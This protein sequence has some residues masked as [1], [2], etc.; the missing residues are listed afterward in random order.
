[1]KLKLG[2]KLVGGFLIVAAIAGAI[3]AVGIVQLNKVNDADTFLYE[4]T[5]VPLAD[6]VVIVSSYQRAKYNAL[7]M[8]HAANPTDLEY[9]YKR[10][11]GYGEASKVAEEDYKKTYI[12]AS[13]EKQFNE[14]LGLKADFYGAVDKLH[15][16]MVAKDWTAS[17]AGLKAMDEQSHKLNTLIDIINKNNIDTA[18]KTSDNNSV[19]A[20]HATMLMLITLF[21]GV[22]I[23]IVLGL[24][25]TRGIL[26]QLGAE[27]SDIAELAD[28]IASGDLQISFDSTGKIVG[29]FKNMKLM[30]DKLTE[31]VTEVR[32]SASN[33]AAGSEQLS[34]SSEQLSQ[35]AN[36]QAASIEEVSASVEE[37]T[38]TIRQNADNASQTEKIASKSATDAREGGE[39]VKQTV[40]A[41]KEIADKVSIIQEIARQT[42]LLSLNASIEAARAGEHGKGFA[43]V[44]SEV[45][46]LAERSQKAA[47]EIGE[48][49]KSSV[50]VAEKAG[51][52]LEKLVPDIQKTAELV[53]EIN[54]ASGEQNNGVQQ[55]NNAVQQLN[56]VV[57]QNASGAEEA[58]STSEELSS[59]AVQLREL[60][61]FFRTNEDKEGVK[62]AASPKKETAVE[63]VKHVVAHAPVHVKVDLHHKNGNGNGNGKGKELAAALASAK[64]VAIDMSNPS[65][66]EDGDFQKY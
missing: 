5:T 26:K 8:Y 54:A 60:I 20:S 37:M 66:S 21:A 28:K 25:L 64:G 55:I 31:V 13:D 36:E 61:S 30:T 49:S 18:K 19:T 47:G 11:L 22:V 12:D 43:V 17:A 39:A 52:M 34:S 48:L 44:A 63:K 57:Q 23:A 4:K 6:V 7:A 10:C 58:A 14:Y 51:A 53:A 15:T 24:F 1:M 45:Q 56:S 2:T 35:G 65:D 42:N 41:M 33:V 29:A 27:P 38:A 3:G 50:E 59:Q 16:T 46:K 40:K 62:R 9:F 32:N